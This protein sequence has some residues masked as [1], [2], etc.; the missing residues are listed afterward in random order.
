MCR[1]VRVGGSRSVVSRR[2][3][4]FRFRSLRGFVASSG[5][6][7]A[8]DGGPGISIKADAGVESVADSQGIVE[9][10][11]HQRRGGRSPASNRT[12]FVSAVACCRSH[13]RD[14]THRRDRRAAYEIVHDDIF[15]MTG[16]TVRARRRPKGA[17]SRKRALWAAANVRASRAGYRTGACGFTPGSQP[18]GASDRGCGRGRC[19]Q[20]RTHGCATRRSRWRS[21]CA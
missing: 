11:R 14:K 2:A 15:H 16:W 9:A 18:R 3:H 1:N 8:G 5:H 7:A 12:R 10:E 20:A 13:K 4:T 6:S 17:I 19:I 21:P